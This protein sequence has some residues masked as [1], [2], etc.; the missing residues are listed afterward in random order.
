[1][2]F[3]LAPAGLYLN[4]NWNFSS[5]FV[6]PSCLAQRLAPN[7]HLPYSFIDVI[8]FPQSNTNESFIKCWVPTSSKNWYLL[9]IYIDNS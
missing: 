4:E 1:M 8:W 5:E 7:K 9:W 3:N 2:Y 6:L